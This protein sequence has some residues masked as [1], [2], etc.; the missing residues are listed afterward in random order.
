M[1]IQ[2]Y[3]VLTFILLLLVS[4][5]PIRHVSITNKTEHAVKICYV[6]PSSVSW[7]SPLCSEVDANDHFFYSAGIGFWS[8]GTGKKLEKEVESITFY[9]SSD[10]I[11]VNQD[12]FPKHV[13]ARVKGLFNAHLKITIK[14]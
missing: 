8:R 9:T 2:I 14:D 11:V 5:D 10:S 1:K 6:N 4:C 7:F 3:S 13:K 12:N